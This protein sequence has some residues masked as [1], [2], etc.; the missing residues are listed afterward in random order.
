[1]TSDMVNV[2]NRISELQKRF[3]LKREQLSGDAFKDSI[4]HK[5]NGSNNDNLSMVLPSETVSIINAKNNMLIKNIVGEDYNERLQNKNI[6]ILDSINKSD[7]ADIFLNNKE[8]MIN[9]AVKAYNNQNKSETNSN[10]VM[11]ME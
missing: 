5:D 9:K 11:E 6:N 4:K 10:N 3:G 2:L 1:M 7:E 8:M